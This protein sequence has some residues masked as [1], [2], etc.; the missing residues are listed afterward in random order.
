MRILFT[1]SFLI[2]FLLSLTSCSTLSS[3]FTTENVMKVHQGM[4]SDEILQL[5]GEPKSIRSA[6][7]GREPNQWTCTTWEYGEFPHDRASFTF[8]GKP[9]NYMLN[10]FDVKRD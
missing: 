10:N 2:C 9:G 1:L 6:V 3:S 4:S 7:C 5:F 8:S